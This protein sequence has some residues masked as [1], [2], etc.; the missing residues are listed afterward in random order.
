MLL[1]IYIMKKGFWIYIVYKYISVNTEPYIFMLLCVIQW[2]RQRV[3]QRRKQNLNTTKTEQKQNLSDSEQ[4]QTDLSL[5]WRF[6]NHYFSFVKQEMTKKEVGSFHFLNNPKPLH[7]KN[8]TFLWFGGQHLFVCI[9]FFFRSNGRLFSCKQV[10]SDMA[11]YHWIQC[12][13]ISLEIWKVLNNIFSTTS[14]IEHNTVL[15]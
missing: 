1:Q 8:L 13:P 4:T 5:Y 6:I 11:I 14:W 2:N 15:V 3:P 10:V 12:I 9:I 7:Q